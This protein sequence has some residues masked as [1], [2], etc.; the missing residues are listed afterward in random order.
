[1]PQQPPAAPRSFIEGLASGRLPWELFADFPE[2][3]PEEPPAQR[4]ALAELGGLVDARVDGDEVDRTGVWPEGLVE[5]LRARGFFQLRGPSG[6]GLTPY[7]LVQLAA[8][9]DSR[10]MG[11]GQ[12]LLVQNGIAAGALLPALEPGPLYDFLSA[13]SAAGAI[14]GFGDTDPAGQNNT[15]P[16]TTATLTE[17]GSAY[18][19]DGEKLFIAN[20]HLADVIGVS[21]TVTGPGGPVAGVFFLPTDTPGFEVI[22][23]SEFIGVNGLS[24]SF[25]LTGARVPAERALLG[26]ATMRLPRAIA[27]QGSYG[28][29][30][31]ASAGALAVLRNC[32][33]YTGEFVARRRIDGRPLAEYDKIQRIIA[34]NLSDEFAVESAV[35]WTMLERGPKDRAFELY[36]TKNLAAERGWRASDRTVSLLGGEGIETERSKRRR[37]AVPHPVE[38]YHRDARTLRVV[39]NVD[40]INDHR[41]GRMLLARHQAGAPAAFQAPEISG[42]RLSEANRRHLGAAASVFP[43]LYLAC[44]RLVAA[45]LDPAGQ[46]EAVI[47]VG[48]LA[49]ELFALCAVLGRAQSEGDGPAQDL[50]DVYAEAALHRVTSLIRRLSA[51]E[52][53]DVPDY[54]GISRAWLAAGRPSQD[55]AAGPAKERV[56][57]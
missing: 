53:S 35:R 40:F 22:S 51:E 21:A 41:A 33:E 52:R 10:S 12:M 7:G 14:S 25:R 5:E 42:T 17:D 39:G 32:L 8:R 26:D 2:P 13:H 6:R 44:R 1:M 30:A 9:A 31:F 4:E 11:V 50:A 3:G 27:L 43:E 29:T 47:L 19:L 18:L 38:R 57:S 45:G 36:V 55:P 28:R 20:A 49:T 23:P 34:A 46:E 37:G 15:L 16:A 48:R 54:A 56:H 24:A